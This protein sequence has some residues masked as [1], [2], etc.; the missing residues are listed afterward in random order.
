MVL[1]LIPPLHEEDEEEE[2]GLADVESFE[3]QFKEGWCVYW[4]VRIYTAYLE[5]L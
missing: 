1:T 5:L 4:H 2:K 3:R